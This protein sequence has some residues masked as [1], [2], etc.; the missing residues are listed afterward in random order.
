ML[1]FKPATR[2]FKLVKWEIFG[3]DIPKDWKN[4]LREI[5]VS[6]VPKE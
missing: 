6:K 3:S 4:A 5:P 2:H 1:K